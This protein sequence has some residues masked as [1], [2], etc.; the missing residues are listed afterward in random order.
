[1]KVRL[2]NVLEKEF[3]LSNELV[4]D[5]V[6]NCECHLRFDIGWCV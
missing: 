4:P 1:M 5:L 2:R 6:S 3:E